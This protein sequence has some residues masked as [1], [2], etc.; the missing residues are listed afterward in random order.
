[1]LI[2]LGW[3]GSPP[4]QNVLDS[5]NSIRQFASNCEVIFHTDESA[6][7][8]EWISAMD[9]MHLTYHMRSDIQRH[10]ILKKY[11]GLWL[12]NDVRLLADPVMWTKGWD[13]YTAIKLNSYTTFIGTDIIYVPSQWGG[14]S[15][16]DNYITNFLFNTPDHI[17]T[18][19]VASTMIKRLA[20]QYPQDF[21]ILSHY[22]IFP[23][24]TNDLTEASVVARGFN[25]DNIY[26]QSPIATQAIPMIKQ[27]KQTDGPGTHLSKMLEKI[28]IKTTPNCSCKAR[29]N[30]MNEKG[31]EWCENNID[32]IVE[33]L[34]EEATKRNLL[35]VEWAARLLVKRAIK[36]SKL[37]SN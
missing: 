16:I 5:V 10:C 35:F 37:N 26:R 24:T 20:K 22:D 30:L 12:D 9:R 4:P 1:M 18:L 7:P 28:G 11:G 34:K 8:S 29:A 31:V 33:W 2:H 27:T 23:F 19:Y 6:I 17:D 3:I 32:T 13:K 15:N 21:N 14:W 36:L 25:P